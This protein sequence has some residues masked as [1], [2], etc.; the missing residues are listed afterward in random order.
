[1]AKAKCAVTSRGRAKLNV[2]KWVK[3]VENTRDRER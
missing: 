1:M 2:Y 3:V